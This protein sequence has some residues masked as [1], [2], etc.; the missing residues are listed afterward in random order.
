LKLIAP[1]PYACCTIDG[2]TYAADEDGM[3][4]APED[5][6]AIFQSFGFQ[7]P[8]KP[9]APK[10]KEPRARYATRPPERDV[11]TMSRAEMFDF[12]REA[13]VRTAGIVVKNEDL[14][15]ICRV[16]LAGG[17]VAGMAGVA[18]A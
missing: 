8:D 1:D 16:I 11:E 12:C 9:I 6:I 3:V 13:G 14:K 18:K 4:D 7:I 17:D 10:P 15:A 5:K 2:A